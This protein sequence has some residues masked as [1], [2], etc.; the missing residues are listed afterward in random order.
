MSEDTE[1]EETEEDAQV[2]EVVEEIEEVLHP[3]EHTGCAITVNG[4]PYLA[5][6]EQNLIDAL[7]DAGV[8]VPRFCYHPRMTPVGMCRMCL[9]EVDTGRGPGLQPP[10]CSR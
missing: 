1:V 5:K 10:A 6:R 4:E 9:I 2:E 8:Y 3:E 7:E